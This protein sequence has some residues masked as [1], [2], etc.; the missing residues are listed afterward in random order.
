MSTILSRNPLVEQVVSADAGADL[1]A[2]LL[3]RQLPL[4]E[5]EYLEALVYCMKNPENSARARQLLNEL[6]PGTKSTYVR[7]RNCD[8]RVAYYVMVDGVNRKDMEAIAGAVHN[9]SLPPEFLKKIAQHGD[10]TMLECLLENQ[11]KLIAYPGIMDVMAANPACGS[12]IQ[13]RIQD[14]HKSYLSDVP[15]QEIPADEVIED[16][17][18]AISEEQ[19]ERA[20]GED[21]DNLDELIEEQVQTTLQRINQMPVSDR[22]KLALTG[23]KTERLILIRDANKMVSVAVIESPKISEDEVLLVVRNRSI[24]GDIIQRIAANREWTKNYNLVVELLNN[25]KTP[26]KDAL[27][28]I[29][30]LHERDLRMLQANKNA[31]PV[32][33]GLALSFIQQ[34]AKKKT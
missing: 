31:S 19:T 16:L 13:A 34:R 3:S 32:I 23:S 14:I 25:P 6:S 27:G 2:M 20:Q 17:K 1:T 12:F 11:I 29:K 10:E 24:S 28:F 9:Q 18:E 33:R 4:T 15:A 22:I 26:V 7:K 21:S 30:K 5:E 8:H